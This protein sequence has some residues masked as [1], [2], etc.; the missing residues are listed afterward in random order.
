VLGYP[1]SGSRVS[2]VS[3]WE[4]WLD[5]ETAAAGPAEVYIPPK[6]WFIGLGHLG[7]GFL[8]NLGLLPVRGSRA[9]LQDDQ[10]VGE[11]NEATGLAAKPAR[12][13][14]RS[15]RSAT[16]S[17]VRE[18]SVSAASMIMPIRPGSARSLL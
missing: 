5:P 14:I 15:N 3:L 8:W 2:I 10:T 7:Q 16:E 4:P 12:S 18:A 9:V 17:A 1:R 11:E 6:L 13:N